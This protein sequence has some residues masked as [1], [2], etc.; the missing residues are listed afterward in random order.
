MRK[1]RRARCE[2]EEEEVLKRV[3]GDGRTTEDMELRHRA[4]LLLLPVVMVLP[5]L[6]VREAEAATRQVPFI[7]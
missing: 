1:R 2:Q 4:R 6:L 3:G 5:V 7:F